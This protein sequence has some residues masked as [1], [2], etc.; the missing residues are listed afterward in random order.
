MLRL[1]IALIVT[2]ILLCGCSKEETSQPTTKAAATPPAQPASAPD[3][4]NEIIAPVQTDDAALKLTM[5][6]KYYLRSCA[7][8]HDNG[9]L[10]APRLGDQAAWQIRIAKGMNVL[11]KNAIRGIGQMPARGGDPSVRREAVTLAVEYLVEKS[12]PQKANQP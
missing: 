4:A 5:G 7:S 9:L 3:R 6:E 11:V 12:L 2:L 1:S 8:C 10:G